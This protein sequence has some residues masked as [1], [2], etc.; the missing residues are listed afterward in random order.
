MSRRKA[1]A[2]ATMPPAPCTYIGCTRPATRALRGKFARFWWHGCPDHA[3][4]MQAALFIG[5]AS[6]S[7][8]VESRQ[9]A[10]P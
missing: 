6:D 4:P 1:P 8:Q 9:V 10:A 2:A 3:G 7:G 5:Q